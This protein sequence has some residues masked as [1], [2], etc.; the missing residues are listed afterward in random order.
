MQIRKREFLST[1]SDRLSGSVGC[2]ASAPIQSRFQVGSC[3]S[4]QFKPT[5]KVST[6]AHTSRALGASLHVTL[7]LPN[8][9]GRGTEANV[10]KVKVS[11]P[12]RLATP[13]KTLQQA[14]T[15]EVFAESPS[16]CPAASDVGY[17]KVETPVLPGGLSGP[18]YFVSHGNTK[19]PELIIVL[20]GEN[21]VTV[22]VHGETS[23][24]KEGITTGTFS[25]T[26][27]VPFTN[28]EL[29]FPQSQYPAFVA[30]GNCRV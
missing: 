10:R 12:K 24:S 28:F 29:T 5:F 27:D 18:A 26:P 21:G 23:I 30:D 2:N 16:K 13:L 20:A 11:L 17:A 9:A 19:F 14:C 7:S 1:H 22:Q 25:T 4:L 8:E 15:A 3:R 6:S